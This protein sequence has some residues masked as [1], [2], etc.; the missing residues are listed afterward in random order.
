MSPEPKPATAAADLQASRP[1]ARNL[2]LRVISSAVL[3]PIAIGIA[4]FGGWVFAAFWTAAA[5]AVWWEWTKLVHPA[6]HPGVL[7]TGVCTLI[8]QA[9]L[10]MIHRADVA[11]M[12]AALGALAA[13][14]ISARHAIWT[15]AGVVYAS[16]LIIAPVM[17]RGD[18]R[19]G[20]FAIAF[21]FAVVWATD[22]VAYFVG[23]AIGGPKLAPAISPNKT[24]SG[25]IGGTIGAVAAGCGVVAPSNAP[26]FLQAALIAIA[27]SVMAQAGDLFES[28]M[29]RIFNVKDSS[30]L[31]PGHGG[32][33][34]RLDGFV[35]ASLA[36][37]VIGV[38]RGG[39]NS[40]AQGLLGW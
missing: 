9:L 17:I 12:I 13:A 29:K 19:S 31:I 28:R 10:V 27:L 5:V 18:D 11:V 38:A 8:I 7:V 2:F 35:T 1:A 20:F 15:A 4:Y 16:V 21:V 23:R 37:L 24:W 34:D 14:I 32:V 39:W 33:M 26:A 25:A 3:A 40:P 6:G 30:T 36:A 22:I